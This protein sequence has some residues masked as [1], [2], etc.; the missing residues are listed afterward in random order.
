MTGKKKLKIVKEEKKNPSGYLLCYGCGQH[1][2]PEECNWKEDDG[3]KIFCHDC[4][5]ENESCGCSD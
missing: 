2:K 5:A 1:E 3:G 4:R